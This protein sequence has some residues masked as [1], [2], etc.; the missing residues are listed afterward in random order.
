[1]PNKPKV[2]LQLEKDL[3]FE[4]EQVELGEIWKYDI[5]ERTNFALNEQGEVVGLRLSKCE[6][7]DLSPLQG[8]TALTGLSLENNQ[9][10]DL[11]PLQGLTA[12]TWLGLYE[13]QISDLSPLQGLTALTGL[14]LWDNQISDLSPL[15]GLTALTGLYL[16]GNQINDLSP[17]QGLTALTGLRL[18]GNQIRDLSPLQGLTALTR[19][20]LGSNQISDLSPLQGLTALTGLDLEHNQISDLSPLQ[21]LTA[22]TG[23]DLEHNQ[24]SDLSPLQ[25]LTAL[26]GLYLWNNQIQEITLDFLNHFP[27][28]ETLFLSENPIKNIPEEIFTFGN[29]SAMRHYLEDLEK[30]Q[31]QTYQAKVILIGN[32]RVGKT[33]LLKRWLDKTFDEKEPSTH[34]IQL[35]HY[36]LKK[37]AKEKQFKTIQLH[38]WDFG[39]QDIYHATHRLFMQTKA[40]FVL[41]WDAQTEKEPEQ[42][43]G[44]HPYRNYPL[45]YWL[46]YAKNLGKNSPILIVQTKKQRDGEQIPKDLAELHKNYNIIA[47]IAVESS[48]DKHNGFTF[49]EQ[50]LMEQV[51]KLL[52]TTCID[53]P[54]SWWQVQ[55]QV[56]K[57]QT[58]KKTLS[59]TEFNKLCQKFG[60]DNEHASSVLLYLHN[61]GTVFYQEN[62]FQNQIILD[63]KWAIDAVYTLFDRKSKFYRSKKENGNFSGEDLQDIWQHFNE[64]E[65]KLFLNFMKSCEIC[66]ELDY[67]DEKPF[68]ERCFIAPA[69]LPEKKPKPS[70]LWLNAQKWFVRYQYRFLHYGNLQSFIVR[71]HQWA[72]RASLWKNG[73]EL[74]DDQGNSTLIE[75]FF[76]AEK[77]YLQIM[78]AGNNPQNLLDKVRNEFD[79]IQQDDQVEELWSLDG[80]EFVRKADIEKISTNNPQFN[81]FIRRNEN[82]VFVIWESELIALK[83]HY[84]KIVEK[85]ECRELSLELENIFASDIPKGILNYARNVLEVIV[86]KICKDKLKRERGTEPLK[87]ILD[88]FKK[89]ETIPEN[90]VSAMFNVN[91]LGTY[92]THPK[93]FDKKQVRSCL[94]DLEIV[95]DWFLQQK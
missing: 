20:D 30:Q 90:I 43:E 92:G 84:Q 88:K 54:E 94:F 74:D 75:G 55:T 48:Q 34:A 15:Q 44:D 4:L 85:D 7:E 5:E 69:L 80:V 18:G 67:D 12:L 23:L 91:E 6:I 21:G 3:G 38:I 39:G 37:L 66:F 31:I 72:E 35:R 8:L 49:F 51:E 82:T 16:N 62:L 61:S 11:S 24:I 50:H 36:P 41:V 33:C 93:S 9:I 1:M 59:L 47:A 86:T 14:D 19:L 10:N 22:L 56:Q 42:R 73:C 58:S 29:V 79:E 13:N 2:I 45:N 46:D 27:Q 32:G 65:Q 70:N 40:I 26:T 53:L 68:S 81:P 52:E 64:A 89:E 25:G 95:L 17:L 87:G 60:L 76:N 83:S 77:P 71:T 28:L 57:W 78:V 63:Q